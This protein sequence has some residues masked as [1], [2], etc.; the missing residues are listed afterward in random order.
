M[1]LLHQVVEVLD[2]PQFA[3]FRER[4]L[5]AFSSLSALG[6]AAFLST[7]ITRWTTVCAAPSA[8]AK[9]RF[10]ACGIPWRAQEKLQGVPAESTAR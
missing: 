1:I 10:A 8:F 4:F 5:S 7:V 3:A 9:N 2:L 6:Y